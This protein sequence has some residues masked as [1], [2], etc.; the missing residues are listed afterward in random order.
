MVDSI[1]QSDNFRNFLLTMSKF[2]NYSIGN[3]I[4]ICCKTDATHVAGFSTWKD[5]AGGS[6]K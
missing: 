3:L 2:H 6:E 4:L 5:L 1:Q